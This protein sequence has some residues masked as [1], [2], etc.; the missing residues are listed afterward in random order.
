MQRLSFGPWLFGARMDL[1]L[2]AG[3]AAFAFGLVLVGR[4][5]GI[6]PGG[7]PEWAWLLCVLGVDVAH[8]W[9]TLFRTYLDGEELRQHPYR[10]TLIPLGVYAAGVAAYL[11]SPMT[12]WRILAYVAV[13]HF[14]RQQVGWVAVY[15][16]R[17]GT[18]NP[19][20]R[21]LDDAAVYAATLYP[22]LYWHANLDHSR[23]AWFMPG[24]FVD[25]SAAL[26]PWV[27]PAGVA[28]AVLLGAFF[29]RQVHK[30]V[31]TRV[32]AAG[33]MIVVATTAA[34]W[35][36]GI[37]ATNNDFDF[38]VTNVIVHGVP[39][40]GL[41]WAYARERRK[42]APERL[43]SQVAAGG[44]GAFVLLLL[45]IAFAEEFVWDRL[46]WRQRD[47]LF[48]DSGAALSQVVLAWVVP[49]LALPQA[50][51]YALDGILWRRGDSRKRPAQRAA[52]GMP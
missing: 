17:A 32:L 20:D 50:T 2:F 21:W 30:A 46:V 28:W 22:V 44:I 33:K 3:S 43:G 1:A 48:G 4:L 38:T 6:S 29:I 23:I 14:V 36:V 41:L 47:W 45:L 12:F 24:D 5:L 16:A 19:L 51:H 34:I 26:H 10:Y 31:T 15:R 7:L 9:S 35:Y 42:Q 13:F 8:V 39:Y 40:V 37:I 52:L 27:M 25:V 18:F 49:L 11:H